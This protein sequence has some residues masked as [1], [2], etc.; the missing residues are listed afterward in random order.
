MKNYQIFVIK[1]KNTLQ[2]DWIIPEMEN[3]DGI[4]YLGQDIP[5]EVFIGKKGTHFLQ[6]S[7]HGKWV[8]LGIGTTLKCNEITLAFRS[9]LHQNKAWFTNGFHLL[10]PKNWMEEHLEAA[11]V[12]IFL[13]SYQL[14]FY[15]K[16][17]DVVSENTFVIQIATDLNNSEKLILKAKHL[18]QAQMSVMRMVDLPA[19]EATPTYLANFAV[20]LT[21]HPNITTKIIDKEEAKSIGLHAFLSVC[22]G[23]EEAPKFIVVDYHP[24]NAKK[25]IGLVGKAITFDTGGY[26]IK[27]QGMYYMKCDMAGGAAVLG[28][29]EW[30]AL[31]QLSYRITAVVPACDS[32]VDQKAYKPSDVISSYAGHSIEITDTDAEG[33]L[34]LADGITY[35][36]RHFQPEIMID[37][38]TLTGS[39]VAT[40]GSV[41]AALF[42]NNESLQQQLFTAG[43]HVGEKVWPMP[44][45]N[46][47]DSHLESDVADVKNYSQK[48]FGGAISA[49][50]FLEYFTE[51]HPS[52]VH[53]DIAGVA[54]V[55]DAF[56]KG[57]H[58]SGY[59]VTLVKQWLQELE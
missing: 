48:P 19:S 51:N 42:T 41:C 9:L 23:S 18:A 27:T 58:A 44:L 32:M 4:N 28:I 1:D 16:K 5:K 50:K 8:F 29:M 45:W 11:L 35:L 53:I 47:F 43:Q 2:G 37:F 25:H 13:A 57:K 12:G 24:S 21:Q 17:K 20:S 39:T 30:A 52:W 38:A 36:L 31:Q 10:V 34:I 54:F 55:D 46:D 22:Q 7:E 3:E 56:A 49:A 40:F 14:D 6:T 26:N 33:R 59:G 15:K